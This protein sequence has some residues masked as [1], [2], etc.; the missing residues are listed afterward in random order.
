MKKILSILAATSIGLLLTSSKV[1]AEQTP[2]CDL[3]AGSKVVLIHSDS[4]QLLERVRQ[5]YPNAYL[6]KTP[7]ILIKNIQALPEEVVTLIWVRAIE[8]TTA[9]ETVDAGELQYL[10]TIAHPSQVY[11]N[12][13][14]MVRSR[15]I[16]YK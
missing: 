14:S 12:N 1:L 5:T 9:K 3:E 10:K 11:V 6:C 8:T 2:R 4:P 13:R 16:R 15:L 7:A